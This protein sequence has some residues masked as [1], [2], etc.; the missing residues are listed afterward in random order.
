MQKILE[1]FEVQPLPVKLAVIF[2][3]VVIIGIL[4][5]Q[6]YYTPKQQEI[7]NLENEATGVKVKLQENQAIAD[8]LPKFREEV[9]ILNEELKRAVDLLPNEADVHGLFRQMSNEAKK[10]NVSVL[11]FRPGGEVNHG[12]YKSLNMD[13][14]IDGTYH[15]IATFIDHVGRLSRIINISDLNFSAPRIEGQSIRLTVSARATT[16]MFAGAR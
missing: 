1:K 12:F 9:D 3:I 5:F 4:E 11:S 7:K 10:T 2:F 15:D 16:F 13:I 14:Q 6:L 8:N